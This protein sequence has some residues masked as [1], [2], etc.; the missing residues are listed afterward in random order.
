MLMIPIP[1]PNNHI[2]V[3]SNLDCFPVNLNT[4]YVE[5][6]VVCATVV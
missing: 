1:G 2:F 3:L 4:F 5:K 6:R